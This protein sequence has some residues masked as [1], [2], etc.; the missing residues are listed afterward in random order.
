[1]VNKY[2]ALFIS[3]VLQGGRFGSTTLREIVN[4]NYFH[5]IDTVKINEMIFNKKKKV[6]I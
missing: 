4:E 6:M 1:M 5:F 3:K 2:P